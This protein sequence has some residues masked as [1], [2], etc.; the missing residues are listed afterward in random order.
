[1][2]LFLQVAK[3]MIFF[4]RVPGLWIL[5]PTVC[6]QTGTDIISSEKDVLRFEAH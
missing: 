6:P 3:G 1:M 2:V 4:R 5:H